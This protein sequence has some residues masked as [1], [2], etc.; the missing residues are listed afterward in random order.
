VNLSSER[1]WQAGNSIITPIGTTQQAGQGELEASGAAGYTYSNPGK[2]IWHLK[3]N[4]LYQL[5]VREK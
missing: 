5:F 2:N 4:H 1:I 3:S